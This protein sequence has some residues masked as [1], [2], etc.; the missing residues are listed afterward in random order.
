M[1]V[2]SISSTLA[3]LSTQKLLG[4]KGKDYSKDLLNNY[5]SEMEDYL[6]DTVSR[7]FPGDYLVEN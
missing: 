5:T 6:L 1:P 2:S 3:D 4:H 7:D